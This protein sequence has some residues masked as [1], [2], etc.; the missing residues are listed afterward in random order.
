MVLHNLSQLLLHSYANLAE[1]EGIHTSTVNYFLITDLSQF[2]V[3]SPKGDIP[4]LKI[5]FDY[6]GVKQNNSNDLWIFINLRYCGCLAAVVFVF[7]IQS[8]IAII[9]DSV[10]IIS[11]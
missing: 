3:I 8:L 10:K 6:L 7:R 2:L 9:H 5:V 11:T 1:T 4:K